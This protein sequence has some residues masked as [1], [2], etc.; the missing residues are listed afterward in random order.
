MPAIRAYAAQQ[1]KGDLKPFE[2]DPGPL[3][4]EHVEIRVTHCGLCHSDLSMLDNEWGMSKY[5]FVPGHE[6]VGTV[7]AIGSHVKT[8]TVGDR[9]GLGWYSESCLHCHQCLTGNHNLCPTVESTIVGRYGGFA[10]RVRAHW[11]WATPLPDA[12]DLAVAGP[13]FCG[14]VTVFNPVVQFGVLPTSRVGVVGIGGLGHLALQFLNKWGCEVTAFSSSAGKT[15]EAKKLGAHHVVNSRDDKEM[16]KLAGAFDFI[17]VTVNVSLNWATYVNALAP[18][19]RL[20]FV[21]AV[22]EPISLAA[23]PLIIGQ[24]SISGSPL[25]SPATTATMLDFCGRHRIA[26]VIET[27]PMSKVNDALAHLRAGKARYRIVLKNDMAG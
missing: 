1:A 3:G 18:R 7:G 25:G 26:P 5:P 8:V 11:L 22:P 10:D 27:F 2:F 14:G 4:D 20:H 16:A 6:V 17:L 12:L 15:D 24:K 21:G 9:V 13:L 23:F 19:G